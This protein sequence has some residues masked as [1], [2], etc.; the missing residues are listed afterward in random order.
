MESIFFRTSTN[1]LTQACEQ[2]TREISASKVDIDTQSKNV[3][4]RIWSES[5][6]VLHLAMAFNN[7]INEGHNVYPL[8]L[9]AYPQIWLKDVVKNAEDLRKLIADSRKINISEQEQIQLLLSD[10]CLIP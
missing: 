5:K 6:P 3:I 9:I 8:K 2:L 10:Y 7:Y 1:S 4:T